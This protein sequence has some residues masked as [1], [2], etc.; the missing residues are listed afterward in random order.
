MKMLCLLG[1][2]RW[3]ANGVWAGRKCQGCQQVEVL[4]YDKDAGERYL[5]VA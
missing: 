3:K 1:Y 2:H 5:K 4:Y